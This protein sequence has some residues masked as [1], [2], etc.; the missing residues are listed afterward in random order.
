MQ[1]NVRI[2]INLLRYRDER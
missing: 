2:V 1:M